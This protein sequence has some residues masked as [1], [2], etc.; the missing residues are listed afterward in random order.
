MVQRQSNAVQVCLVNVRYGKMAPLRL[1]I[2]RAEYFTY[3]VLEQARC[4]MCRPKQSQSS[5]LDS[6]TQ[7]A[8]NHLKM[9]SRTSACKVPWDIN[10]HLLPSS[11]GVPL[12]SENL[13]IFL[14]LFK[15]LTG[16]GKN[17][18][19]R[20]KNPGVFWF[21]FVFLVV[22]DVFSHR[23]YHAVLGLI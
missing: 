19:A 8:I 22:V 21:C 20:R 14:F 11:T 12:E 3:S 4:H 16:K 2:Y 18:I 5:Q 1:E 17:I 15:F 6:T 10:P 13:F 23:T 9:E 7:L